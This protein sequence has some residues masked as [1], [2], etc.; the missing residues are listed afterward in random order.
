VGTERM[1]P[2]PAGRPRAVTERGE[3]R[4]EALVEA[5]AALLREG[6]FAAVSHRAVAARAGLPLAATTY[7]FASLDEL[8]E[9]ALG[10]LA[11]GHLERARALASSFPPAPPGS[12]VPPEEL[13]SRLIA[14]VIGSR[15]PADQAG[16]LP[17]HERYIQA[18]RRP[19]LRPLVGAWNAELAGLV[20]ETLER[21]GYPHQG[22][23]PRVLMATVDGLL[24]DQLAAGAQ[25]AP[26]GA[27]AGLASLLGQL[28]EAGPS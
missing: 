9:R 27:R 19:G 2:E 17:L 16:M 12:R 18:G 24:I 22:D 4:R 10:R 25:D 1:A 20:A 11:R 8:V 15:E 6:G 14:L 13:A 7:Y 28:R 23:L 5:A 26:A 3:R 21:C